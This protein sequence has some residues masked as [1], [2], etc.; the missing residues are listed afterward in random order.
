MKNVA[1]WTPACVADPN[2]ERRLSRTRSSVRLI[3]PAE[4]RT[5]S[6]MKPLKKTHETQRSETD[7]MRQKY[8]FD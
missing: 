6:P 3:A 8:D 7:D 5:Y 4:T 2:A 1:M